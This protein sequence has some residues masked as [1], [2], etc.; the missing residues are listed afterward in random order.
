MNTESILYKAQTHFN[1]ASAEL[2]RP[3][4]DVVLPSAC[5]S[6]KRSL[7]SYLEAYL[8]TYGIRFSAVA[9]LEQLM[10]KCVRHNPEFV[11]FDVSGMEC[12]CDHGDAC[13]QTFCMDVS[14]TKKCEHL[15]NEVRSFVIRAVLG[16]GQAKA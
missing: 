15:L 1:A 4:E 16:N 11:Q 9:T 12:K 10:E 3:A 2:A 13:L 8:T 6:I 5:Y 7:R 14:R